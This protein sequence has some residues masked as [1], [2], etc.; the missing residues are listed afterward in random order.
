MK[1]LHI[2]SS[3]GYVGGSGAHIMMNRL[4]RGLKENGVSS[5]IICARK[6][7]GHEDVVEIKRSTPTKMAERLLGAIARRLGLNEL[8][9]FSCLSIQQL[10][11]FA[12]AD[13]IH[14]HGI[15][16]GFFSYLSLPKFARKKALVFTLHD[17][18]SFTG[19]CTYS[20]E[21]E[22]WKTGCGG[23]PHPED[24]P[25]IR[26]DSTR[27]EWKLKKWVYGRCRI[28]IVSI[29]GRQN[30]MLKESMLAHFPIHQIKNA[31]ETDIYHPMDREKCRTELNIPSDR[32]VIMFGA[33]NMTRYAKGGDLLAEALK[34]LPEAVKEQVILLSFGLGGQARADDA[35]IPCID[36]GYVNGDENKARLYSAADLF[37]LSSRAET[38]EL[39][40]LECMACGTPMVSFPVGAAA[41]MVKPGVTGYLAEPENPE[42][43]CRGII[44]L[45][46][47][48]AGRMQMGINARK[49]AETE[50][51]QAAHVQNYQNLYAEILNRK[52]GSPTP[53]LPRS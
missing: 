52:A 9:H 34:L 14:F 37:V 5:K 53:A 2:H 48:D 32:K 46:E 38:F 51:S 6:S 15:H 4:H 13:L 24:Y 8:V 45:L 40:T 47:D 27:L 10:P 16:S 21:C 18:W 20:Y 12:D 25:P 3:D 29:S 22:K 41:E 1:V 36:M 7:P 30:E 42:D 31:I 35:G 39:V 49:L 44:T 19:H 23:C 11:D 28:D 33:T 26:R 50:Y 17:M 43:L